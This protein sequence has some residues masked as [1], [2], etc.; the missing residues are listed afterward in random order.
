VAAADLPI[1]PGHLDYGDALA[2]EVPSERGAVAAGPFD[3]DPADVAE[4]AQPVEQL[5]VAGG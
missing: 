5:P 1:G 4:V 2:G 3:T